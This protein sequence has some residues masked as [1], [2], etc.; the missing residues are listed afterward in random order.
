[1]RSITLLGLASLCA[2][3]A[4]GTLACSPAAATESTALCKVSESTCSPENQVKS[5]HMTSERIEI[6]TSVGTT[7]CLFS[8]IKGETSGLG[9]PLLLK[10]TEMNLAFCG[11]CN[12]TVTKL[13]TFDVLKILLNLATAKA[14]GF[15]VKLKCELL[16]C[17]FEGPESTWE[18]EGA[19]HNFNTGHGMLT[20]VEWAL[21]KKEGF[22]CPA[23]AKFTALF[24]P[25]EHIYVS[26]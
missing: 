13:P 26:S 16:E 7:V 6:K 1:M 20:S 5:V 23:E 12:A 18:L 2:V 25:L 10:L 8:L 14:L 19:L 22:F 3:A 9:Q 15:Q 17:T 21:A 24:E 4:L 11:G